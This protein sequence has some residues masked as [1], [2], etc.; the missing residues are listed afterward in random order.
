MI[1]K[2]ILT[3]ILA[4]L[5]LAPA[6]LAVEVNPQSFDYTMEVNTTIEDH[7]NITTQ[8][9][10][11]E[12]VTVE[13]ADVDYLTFDQNFTL[14]ENETT[15]VNFT[16]SPTE[17]AERERQVDV[18]N[19]SIDYTISV[20]EPYPELETELWD[21]Y[22][23]ESWG[24]TRT[25]LIKV[26]NPSDHKARSV[27]FE[28]E[29]PQNGEL[30]F[31][32]QD[33]NLSAGEEKFIEYEI[34]FPDPNEKYTNMTNQ[35][36]LY[37]VTTSWDNMEESQED[38][39]EYFKPFTNYTEEIE[40]MTSEEIF[41]LMQDFCE[42]YP[43]SPLCSPEPETEEEIV[44]RKEPLELEMN[45]TEAK[46]MLTAYQDLKDASERYNE[47]EMR[48]QNIKDSTNE[49]KDDYRE[50]E[51]SL[52]NTAQEM[53]VKVDELERL[54]NK[55]Y[56]KDRQTEGMFWSYVKTTGIILIIFISIGFIA[57]VIYK[58]R[59]MGVITA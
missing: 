35:S 27:K 11:Y 58:R 23:N 32:L 28:K 41:E 49:V 33:F 50:T 34:T 22:F 7:F 44:Y 10:S 18:L 59:S 47:L 3:T 52:N 30:T 21:D 43:D 56:N 45:E 9:E 42:E 20:H 53:D 51:E 40:G 16:V 39:I 12:N 6:T 55:T 48:F 13:N 29:V 4:F 15:P 17:V 24:E 31:D 14:P 57:Y 1:R 46:E 2:P 5:L 37:N 36:Y 38:Q 54:M 19:N 26:Y 25:S 8:D